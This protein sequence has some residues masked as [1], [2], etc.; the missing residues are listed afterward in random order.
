[1]WS[2]LY[3]L[4]PCPKSCIWICVL[5]CIR[6]CN[7]ISLILKS[8]IC[9][10]WVWC[11]SL[12]YDR[13][14]D[15]SW[16]HCA[17]ILVFPSIPIHSNSNNAAFMPCRNYHNSEMTTLMFNSVLFTTS[18]DY[19]FYSDS[20]QNEPVWKNVTGSCKTH[21]FITTLHLYAT[22]K[23][24]RTQKV[25][26]VKIIT[27]RLFVIINDGDKCV[28]ANLN[29][30]QNNISMNTYIMC[31]YIIVHYSIYICIYFPLF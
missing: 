27:N 21:N 30:Q 10:V 20:Q 24:C 11:T 18:G 6:P 29:K 8:I 13:E 7:V 31:F 2:I 12:I 3:R 17:A 26:Q 25:C 15:C 23:Y 5:S 22:V 16:S 14:L 4:W 1:M 19:R 28:I 9:K